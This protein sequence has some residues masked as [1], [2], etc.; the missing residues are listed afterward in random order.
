ME[1]QRDSK[2]W[3][4][5][6]EDSKKAELRLGIDNFEILRAKRKENRIE[7]LA[8]SMESKR[9]LE[10]EYYFKPHF[11]AVGDPEAQRLTFHETLEC[12]TVVG[13]VRVHWNENAKAAFVLSGPHIE[14]RSRSEHFLRECRTRIIRACRFIRRPQDYRWEGIRAVFP[15]PTA[16]DFRPVSETRYEFQLCAFGPEP[17]EAVWRAIPGTL[18][19]AIGDNLKVVGITTLLEDERSILLR[20]RD[21]IAF[22]DWFARALAEPA[23]PPISFYSAV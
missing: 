21:I 15:M 11:T 10:G 16:E 12:H 6:R 1:I 23:S 3:V 20:Y 8:P 5:L 22:C 13:D 18:F 2:L 9:A 14:R 19:S 17:V 4:D 7:F